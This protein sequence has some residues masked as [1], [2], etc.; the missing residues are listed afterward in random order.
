MR[1]ATGK[2]KLARPHFGPYNVLNLT[3]T[4][5]EVRLI[6]KPDD[7]LIFVSFDRV[8]PCYLNV[9]GVGMPPRGS[10]RGNP[11]LRLLTNLLVQRIYW[12]YD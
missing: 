1:Q 12:S 3:T 2:T 6:N 11:L 9:L 4:N 7:P 8:R 10:V 5:V